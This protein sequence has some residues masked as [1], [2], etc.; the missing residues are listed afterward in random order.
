MSSQNII[1]PFY[2]SMHKLYDKFLSNTLS[3][4]E[5]ARLLNLLKETKH[6]QEFKIY[7]LEQRDVYVALQEI[8]LR[9][10]YSNIQNCI[11]K[12]K[13]F[14]SRFY[15]SM[16]KYTAVFIIFLSITLGINLT[17]NRKNRSTI[18]LEKNK[19]IKSQTIE[20]VKCS[21]ITHKTSIVTINGKN[22]KEKKYFQ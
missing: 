12:P 20:L 18:V 16:F 1:K 8:D 2:Q 3:P 5:Q 7:M 4:K 19:E 10:A 17:K 6:K 15:K 14:L 22:K 9:L 13:N 11:H 21:A